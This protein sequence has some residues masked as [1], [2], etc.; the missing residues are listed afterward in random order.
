[1]NP[2]HRTHHLVLSKARLSVDKIT[3]GLRVSHFLV[4]YTF[5]VEELREDALRSKALA[6][7]EAVFLF[8]YKEYVINGLG[9]RTF[10]CSPIGVGYIRV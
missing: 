6:T 8:P 10:A 7:K 1:M 4:S 5:I 9:V 2:L 3:E